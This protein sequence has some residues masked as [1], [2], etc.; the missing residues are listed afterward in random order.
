MHG[1]QDFQLFDKLITESGI[2]VQH[3]SSKLGKSPAQIWRYRKGQVAIKDDMWI[4]LGSVLKIDITP[5]K[6]H[7]KRFIKDTYIPESNEALESRVSDIEMQYRNAADDIKFL[8]DRIADYDL[9]IEAKN[10]VIRQQSET[11]KRLEKELK[12]HI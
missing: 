11:I 12:K 2:Q 4:K 10:E 6:P 3:L 9:M 8:K 7:L 5:Y 1:L